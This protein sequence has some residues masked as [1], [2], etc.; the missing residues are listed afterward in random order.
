[1]W[2][3]DYTERWARKNCCFGTV[4][5]EKT[6]ESPL[7]CKVIQPVHPKGNQSWIFIGRTDAKV[8]TPILMWRADSLEKTQILRL[9]EGERKRGW[10]GW[11]ASPS[12]WTWAWESSRSWWWKRRPGMLQSMGW[13]RV[14]YEWLTEL[15]ELN[16]WDQMP[17]VFLM[18]SFKPA[19]SLSSFTL[20]KRLFSSSSFLPLECYHLHIWG[21]WYFSWQSWF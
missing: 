10:D 3:L 8:E 18:L 5:L 7:D 15:T 12:L 9:I 14:R 20:I 21:C 2:A 6:L 11:M 1:M 4:V 13:Q 17:L 16:Q 19:F